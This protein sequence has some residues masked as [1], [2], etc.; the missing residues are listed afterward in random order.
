MGLL[1]SLSAA[2]ARS[3][4]H[5]SLAPSELA[6]SP[7]SDGQYASTVGQYARHIDHPAQSAG[8]E[9]TAEAGARVAHQQHLVQPFPAVSARGSAWSAKLL[10]PVC[11]GMHSC[12]ALSSL[13]SPAGPQV[14]HFTVIGAPQWCE[15]S[16]GNISA[17]T[18]VL[19]AH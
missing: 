11:L 18:S 1:Q 19:N 10:E 7:V 14:V 17:G 13:E 4:T 6:P 3:L 16:Q 15:A 8:H 2:S 5:R 9:G 12:H